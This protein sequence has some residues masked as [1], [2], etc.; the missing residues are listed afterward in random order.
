[1]KRVQKAGAPLPCDQCLHRKVRCDK[2]LPRCQRCVESSLACTRDVIRRRPGRKKGSGNVIT[3]LRSPRLD[4]E[5]SVSKAS[6]STLYHG[7]DRSRGTLNGDSKSTKGQ[8]PFADDAALHSLSNEQVEEYFMV[9]SGS[10]QAHSTY[11]NPRTK[12]AA[13][14]SAVPNLLRHIDLFFEKLYPIWP[15]IDEAS[16]REFLEYPDRLD[17]TQI[18]L[19]LSICALTALHIPETTSLAMEPRKLVAQR[20]LKECLN[21]RSQ[22]P[23]IETATIC[24]IQTSLF[25]SCAEVEFLRV[26]S[27]FFLLR[28]SIMLAQELSFYETTLSFPSLSPSDTLCVR[29]T[30]YLLNLVERGLTILRN[31]PFAINMFDSPPSERFAIEDPR[32]LIGLKSLSQLFNLLDK[33][34]LDNWVN[35][36]PGTPESTIHLLSAQEKLASMEFDVENLTDIQKADILIAQ[37]WLRLVFWQSSMRQGIIS[38]TAEQAALSYQY[39]CHI[40]RSLCS[41]LES[42]PSAIIFIHGMAIVSTNSLYLSLIQYHA[43]WDHC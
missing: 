20:F 4:I 43:F 31:K 19:I 29:R 41:V 22:F 38:S 36:T 14:L 5:Q 15:I 21:I 34:F 32:I 1:M 3:R 28:E 35:N 6:S 42:L 24:T 10:P 39:P 12:P 40:A 26:R 16:F 33:T 2:L 30:L 9:E 11:G 18:C 37:Q 23:Y 8:K 13:I 27:S 25:L 7:E 17:Y